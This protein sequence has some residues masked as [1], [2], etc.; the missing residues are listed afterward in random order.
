KT[1]R[2][3]VKQFREPITDGYQTRRRTKRLRVV[4]RPEIKS[5]RFAV[6]SIDN[7]DAGG[8]ER[9]IDGENAHFSEGNRVPEK[10][11]RQF[12]KADSRSKS[13]VSWSAPKLRQS[14]WQSETW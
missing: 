3:L 9:S 6:V 4:D 11:S 7:R 2:V 8:A 13:A 5:A 14:R 1:W 10:R 12:Q